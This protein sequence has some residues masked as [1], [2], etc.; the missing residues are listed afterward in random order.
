MAAT[1]NGPWQ[2]ATGEDAAFPATGGRQVFST[3]LRNGNTA[4]A[5]ALACTHGAKPGLLCPASAL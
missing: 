2:L 1:V 4:R 5:L 3:A